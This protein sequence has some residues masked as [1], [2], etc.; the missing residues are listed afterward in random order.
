MSAPKVAAL[1]TSLVEWKRVVATLNA[2]SLGT[3]ETSLVEWKHVARHGGLRY[4]NPTLETS[5]VEWKHAHWRLPP[6]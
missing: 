2:V 3:L 1:E 4:T 6:S 5:L